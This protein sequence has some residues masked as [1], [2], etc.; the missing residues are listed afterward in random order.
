MKIFQNIR[1]NIPDWKVNV[2][3]DDF[4]RKMNSEKI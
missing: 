1:E 2:T 4:Q 3:D